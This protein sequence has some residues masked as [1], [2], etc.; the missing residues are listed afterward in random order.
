M[1]D[2][3]RTAADRPEVEPE[4]QAFECERE[5]RIWLYWLE[6]LRDRQ[7]VD[8]AAL[9]AD[10]VVLQYRKRRRD[11]DASKTVSGGPG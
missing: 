5:A 2:P 6:V 3:Y 8:G 10:W 11:I 1:T 7:A 9:T 4:P